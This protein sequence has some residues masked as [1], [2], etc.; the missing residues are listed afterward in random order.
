MHREHMQGP[1][2]S[3]LGPRGSGV[4]EHLVGGEGACPLGRSRGAGSA[5][6]QQA[7]AEN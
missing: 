4:T 6:L 7:S 2:A 3:A 1:L 5:P